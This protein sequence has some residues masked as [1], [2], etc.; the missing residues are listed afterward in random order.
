MDY[1]CDY[2]YIRPDLKSGQCIF[3]SNLDEASWNE[4]VR[5]M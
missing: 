3:D 2:G 4:E 1:E 5:K